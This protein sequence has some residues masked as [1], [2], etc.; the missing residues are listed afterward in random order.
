MINASSG[1][2]FSFKKQGIIRFFATEKRRSAIIDKMNTKTIRQIVSEM[3]Q[4]FPLEA[5][6]SWDSG[7]LNLGHWDTPVSSFCVALEATPFTVSE[8]LKQKSSLL[9][10]HHPPLFGG[11][12]HLNSD[13]PTA[14]A[15]LAAAQGGLS[16]VSWHTA[17]DK[18]GLNHWL[19]ES[20]GLINH[21][22]LT[23]DGLGVVGSFQPCSVAEMVQKVMES[24]HLRGCKVWG[25][26]SVSKVALCGGAG[27]EF[28][29][30]AYQCG[31]DLYITSELKRHHLAW[32]LGKGLKVVEVDHYEVEAFGMKRFCLELEGFLGLKGTFID[33]LTQRPVFQGEWKDETR[34]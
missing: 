23:E 11:V 34:F 6:E 7:G 22:V 13:D 24:W 8:A 19:G 32:A 12:T 3:D 4:R 10:L 18:S 20:L 16:L 26:G 5:Q 17:L 33:D 9:I 15:V 1:R 2:R 14:Q 25:E 27:S 31:A 21:E 30:Q 28:V 29:V